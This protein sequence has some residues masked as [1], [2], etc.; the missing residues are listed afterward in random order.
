MRY[1]SC[2]AVSRAARSLRFPLCAGP[3]CPSS[4][5]DTRFVYIVVQP[6]VPDKGGRILAIDHR[7]TRTLEALA[8]KPELGVTDLAQRVG[9]SPSRL[10][11]LIKSETGA[12]L[13]AHRCECRMQKAAQ[14]L[15]TTDLQIS[16][17]AYAVGFSHTANLAHEFRRRFG[18]SASAFRRSQCYSNE[19]EAPSSSSIAGNAKE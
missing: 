14:L 10:Q 11:H 8:D 12:P 17:V 16:Q 19:F 9:L 18:V 13:R 2:R 5:G 7:V 4:A 15:I 6:F 3:D 1:R